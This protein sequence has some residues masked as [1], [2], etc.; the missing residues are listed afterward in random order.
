[1]KVAI[2]GG[3]STWTPGL[4]NSIAR[5]KEKF[6]IDELVLYDNNPERQKNVGEFGKILFREKYEGLKFDYTTDPKKAFED[7]DYVFCQIRTG[8]YE[9]REKDEKIPLNMG[10]IGQ[11]TCGP[12]GFAYGFRSI[13]DMIDLINIIL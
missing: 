2:A 7:V 8:G 9:M 3:G 5:H 10:L 6:P 11:E 1:M 12:G 4:L 13:P